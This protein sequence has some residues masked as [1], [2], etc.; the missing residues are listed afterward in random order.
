MKRLLTSLLVAACFALSAQ[1]LLNNADF[2]RLY[3]P[4]P[5]DWGTNLAGHPG[6]VTLLPNQ[7]P[8]KEN[9]VRLDLSGL[10]SY[11]QGGIRLVPEESYEIGAW[12][13]TKDFH[14][15]RGGI[16]IYNFGW[17]DERG[18]L[19]VPADTNGEWVKLTATVT[20]PPPDTQRPGYF[21]NSQ[22]YDF[23]IFATEASGRLDVASPFLIPLSAKAGEFSRRGK[24]LLDNVR[25]VPVSPRLTEIPSRNAD[26]DFFWTNTPSGRIRCTI[27][28]ASGAAS[29][30]KSELS[31]HRAKLTFPKLPAG[32]AVM[33]VEIDQG[34]GSGFLPAGSYTVNILE[35]VEQPARRLNNLVSEIAC[36]KIEP[37]RYVF[38]FA[39][40]GWMYMKSAA[41]EIQVDGQP[42]SGL[43]V[44]GVREF[45]CL[46]SAGSHE[47]RLDPKAGAPEMIRKI[48]ELL[49]F[50]M[51]SPE[52]DEAFWMKH[53]LPQVNMA[54]STVFWNPRKSRKEYLAKLLKSGRRILCNSGVHTRK[55]YDPLQLA[56]DFRHNPFLLYDGCGLVYDELNPS[57]SAPMIQA[58]SEALWQLQNLPKPVRIWSEWG[59][60]FFAPQIH[61]SLI[62]AAAN[63]S[64][65]QGKIL[66]EAYC[67]L[68]ADEKLMEMELAGY[69]RSVEL[70][71]SYFPGYVKHLMMTAGTYFTPRSSILLISDPECDP[72]VGID[73]YFRMCA[74]DPV[75]EDLYG[76]G[77]YSIRDADEEMVRWVGKLFRH[78]G[79]EGRK[80]LLSEKYGFQLKTNFLK[81][82]DFTEGLEHWT[83]VGNVNTGIFEMLG[84]M[85]G[86]KWGRGE[87]KEQKKTLGDTAAVLSPGSAVSQT[88]AGLIPGRRY[89]VTC[90]VAERKMA[91]SGKTDN[92]L[93]PEISVSLSNADRVELRKIHSRGFLSLKGIF[94]AKDP[95]TDITFAAPPE[96]TD[97]LLLNYAAIRPYFT[98]ETEN[99]TEF[100][101]KISIAYKE[102]RETSYWLRLPFTSKYLTE[103]QFNSL[104]TDCE[105]LIRILGSAQ[106][107]MRTKIQKGL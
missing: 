12:V 44:G 50:A 24:T 46:I 84:T 29:E 43:E 14:C 11:A 51:D 59:G 23:T 35:P 37:G 63:A 80:E 86:R 55:K 38:S 65:G 85:Q 1:N 68:W 81:N 77:V 104:H 101:A 41:S 13:R 20:C 42:L 4:Y 8:Q 54:S 73:L 7:G 83:T 5:M 39:E 2:Q 22:F 70:V 40:G 52:Y 60:R 10:V 27:T 26:I 72:K 90:I 75:F 88:A 67:R 64:N 53:L 9:A 100:Q 32:P 28:P 93:R 98:D 3:G 92:N 33:K 62:A 25:A 56:D 82:G 18:V 58:F 106:L 30:A 6:A 94:T 76:I 36:R 61:T 49:A 57:S 99:E 71:Q 74:A 69:R 17:I 21:R 34:D 79:I 47:I 78:Y 107:A 45:M 89:S 91:E 15:T 16:V 103:R 66:A 31:D 96:Q 19:S 87:V 48:P 95:Q 97:D 105:D 102:A